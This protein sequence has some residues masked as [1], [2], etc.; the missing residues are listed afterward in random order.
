MPSWTTTLTCGG[1]CGCPPSDVS[2]IQV[3]LSGLSQCI[4]GCNGGDTFGINGV[5]IKLNGI[6][7]LA[8]TGNS[9]SLTQVA[10]QELHYRTAEGSIE[11]CDDAD[12]QSAINVD[13]VITASCSGGVWTISYSVGAW[14][15]FAGTGLAAG[16]PNT[17]DCSGSSKNFWATGGTATI[18]W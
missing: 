18:S 12:L 9:W 5:P 16:V 1:C 15:W 7:T 13:G 4:P 17:I 2:S 14:G 3:V 10:A 8:K 11:N 6:Y